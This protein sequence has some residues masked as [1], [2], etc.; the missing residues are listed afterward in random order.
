VCTSL[1][2][3][4][5]LFALHWHFLTLYPCDRVYLSHD[6]GSSASSSGVDRFDVSSLEAGGSHQPVELDFAEAEVELGPEKVQKRVLI[7]MSDTGG[8]HRASAE[9]LKA[10]FELE[11][12]DKYKV[13]TQPRMFKVQ[14]L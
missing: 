1:Q 10:T 14:Q 4:A 2:S 8:G 7:L 13:S 11:F 6:A 9:A 5:L 3:C 12:G